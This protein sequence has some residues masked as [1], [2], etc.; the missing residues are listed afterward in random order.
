MGKR[1]ISLIV[2][3]IAGIMVIMMVQG[4]SHLLFPLAEGVRQNSIE[5]MKNSIKN[6]PVEAL[7]FVILSYSLGSF[8]GGL[9]NALIFPDGKY[10]F[11]AIIG[12]VLMIFGIINMIIIPH[13]L[14]FWIASLIIYIPSALLGAKL[15]RT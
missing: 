10:L 12:F 6:L 13:P 15:R 5:A 1:I 8:T 14:W 11:P 4:L 7:L 9:V 3:L 2:G